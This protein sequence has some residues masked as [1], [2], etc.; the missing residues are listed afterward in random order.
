[1]TVSTEPKLVL[2]VGGNG[3]DIPLP[4]YYAGYEHVLLDIAPGP[5]VDIVMDARKLELW[6]GAMPYF[7]AVYCSHNLEHYYVHDVQTVLRGFYKLLKPGGTVWIVVPDADVVFKALADGADLFDYAYQNVM[8]HDM[9]YGAN[10][11][12]QRC[13]DGWAHK[14]AFTEARLRKV[15]LE[16]GFYKL[17]LVHDT[18]N[19]NLAVLAVK[20]TNRKG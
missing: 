18:D 11:Y 12:V 6:E 15:L 10:I 9:L 17:E 14:T 2:N 20:P 8:W 1:M 4:D 7:D 5:G 3:K 16:A 13:G 19:Y